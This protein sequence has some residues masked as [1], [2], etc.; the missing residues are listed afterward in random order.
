VPESQHAVAQRQA[1]ELGRH[2]LPIGR[3]QPLQSRMPRSF[4]VAG[5]RV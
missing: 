4:D 1:L 3:P 5:K 2:L